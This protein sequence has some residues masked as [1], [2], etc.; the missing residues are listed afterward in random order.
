M[1]VA[2][3]WA[4]TIMLTV[5]NVFPLKSREVG[6]FFREFWLFSRENPAKSADF[7]ANFDLF[8]G[9]I[10]DI[11]CFSREFWLFSRENPAKL[12]DFSANFP[13]KI[14]RNFA[15]F[16]AKY[17]KP[18]FCLVLLDFLGSLGFLF[19]DQPNNVELALPKNLVLLDFKILIKTLLCLILWF[20]LSFFHGEFAGLR[21]TAKNLGL[22]DIIEV[23]LNRY[24]I[25]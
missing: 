10:P 18:C 5:D 9:K 17:Q 13:L 24:A 11:A 1:N 2:K 22:G 6:R 12:A 20:P 15:F 7:S 3:N 8:P 21:E 19:T 23:Q 4:L 25:F 14:P 16:S